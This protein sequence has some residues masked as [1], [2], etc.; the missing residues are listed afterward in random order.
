MRNHLTVAL[1]MLAGAAI[2]AVA[3]QGLHAQSKPPVYQITE[4]DPAN[5]DTYVKDYVPRAQA[6]I[7]AAG[8]HLVAAG[9][10]TA[11]DGEPPMPRVTV[12]T[13]DSPEKFQAYRNSAAFKELLPVREK[14][15]KFRSFTVDGVQYS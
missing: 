14:L 11:V 6:V 3:V 13:W 4:I 2:G 10:A 7:K 1:S 5:L 8:G 9:H 12:T 15:A